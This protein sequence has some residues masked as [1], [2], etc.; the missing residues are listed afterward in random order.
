[1]GIGL[2][3]NPHSLVTTDMAHINFAS[4]DVSPE[5]QPDTGAS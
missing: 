3:A 2:R 5:L 4:I 1:M